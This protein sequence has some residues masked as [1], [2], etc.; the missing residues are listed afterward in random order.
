[1]LGHDPGDPASRRRRRLDR[2][3]RHAVHSPARRASGRVAHPSPREQQ[4]RQALLRRRS[5]E[6]GRPDHRGQRRPRRRRRGRGGAAPHRRR[7]AGARRGSRAARRVID[8]SADFRLHDA[9]AYRRGTASSTRH[10]ICSAKPCTPWSSCSA[11]AWPCA[12][13]ISVPGCYPTA[14]LLACVPALR[15]GS[16]R[17]RHHRRR[18]EWR[19]RRGPRGEGRQSLL[20]GQRVRCTRTASPGTGTSRRC[21][22]S[23]VTPRAATSSSPSC[24]T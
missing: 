22:S 16:D 5:G 11:N 20:G 1:M 24:R 4:R 17:A 2:L 18:Q 7:I 3:H 19:Q 8:C 13:L 23:C 15:A 10:R 12:N 21:S 14:A 9:A 6:H